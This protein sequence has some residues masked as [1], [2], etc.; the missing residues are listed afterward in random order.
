MDDDGTEPF[1]LVRHRGAQILDQVDDDCET[2]VQIAWEC[3]DGQLSLA[4][5]DPTPLT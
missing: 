5:S 2:P 4:L 3:C 1:D